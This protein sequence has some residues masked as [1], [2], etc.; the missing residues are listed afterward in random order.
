MKE[1][2]SLFSVKDIFYF[3][4]KGKR[5]FC[6]F[7]QKF[8]FFFENE[9]STKEQAE[10]F[11]N[12]REVWGILKLHWQERGEGAGVAKCFKFINKNWPKPS[13]SYL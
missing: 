12:N 13:K 11:L 5:I 1:I 8:F 3:F 9:M 10:L 2:S 6:G 7:S 4:L